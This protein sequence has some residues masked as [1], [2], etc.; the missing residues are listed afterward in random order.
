VRIVS[1]TDVRD[2]VHHAV[3]HAVDNDVHRAT[4]TVT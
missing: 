1:D 3:H 2:A 4:G